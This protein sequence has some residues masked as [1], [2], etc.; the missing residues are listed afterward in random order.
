MIIIF[1]SKSFL[2]FFNCLRSY[3]FLYKSISFVLC[4]PCW[5]NFKQRQSKNL[6]RDLTPNSFIVFPTFELSTTLAYSLLRKYCTC[7]SGCT[8]IDIFELLWLV[9]SAVW[10]FFTFSLSYSFF[11]CNIFFVCWLNMFRVKF[12]SLFFQLL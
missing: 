11:Y 7:L 10:K 9:W 8:E 3:L 4:V 6:L 1:Y 2:V 12:N 5:K